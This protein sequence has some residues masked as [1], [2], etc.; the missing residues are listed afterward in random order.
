MLIL[1]G[2]ARPGLAMPEQTGRPWPWSSTEYGPVLGPSFRTVRCDAGLL[3]LQ[4]NAC[5]SCTRGVCWLPV[6]APLWSA[7]P[8]PGAPAPPQGSSCRLCYKRKLERLAKS[9]SSTK[10]KG[11]TFE[12]ITPIRVGHA[13]EKLRSLVRS[14]AACALGCRPAT[15]ARRAELVRPLEKV[16]LGGIITRRTLPELAAVVGAG[17]CG[18]LGGRLATVARDACNVAARPEAIEGYNEGVLE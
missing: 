7:G 10:D 1:P 6:V 12:K 2:E 3:Q 14:L 13:A 9:A 15:L 5:S 4:I 8:N 11:P 17:S 16:A 18:Q